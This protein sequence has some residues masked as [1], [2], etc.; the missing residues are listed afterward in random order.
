M[1]HHE[2]YFVLP[3][4][5]KESQIILIDQEVHHLSHVKRHREGDVIWAVDGEGGAYE[6]E[7]IRITKTRAVARILNTRRQLGEPRADVT[8]AQA[9]IKGDRFEWLIEKCVEIGIR[10]IIPLMTEK[11]ILKAGSGRINRWNRVA[12][13]AMKQCGRSILP[14]IT[15]PK[16]M[17]QICAM[18]ADCQYRL[19]AHAGERSRP[20]RTDMPEAR[21]A[22]KAI[23]MTGPEGGFTDEEIDM[24][25]ENG[26]TPVSL[27]SRRL[28]AETAGIVLSTIILSQWGE[29]C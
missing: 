16:T 14:E 3:E 1:S 15:E 28:R 2:S 7:L 11:T 8:L 17:K 4:N 18:G 26:Y 29:L 12:L 6:V 22:P 5:V 27:G 25:V 20:V 9:M 21:L 24:A 23:G 13:G 19:I 10:R